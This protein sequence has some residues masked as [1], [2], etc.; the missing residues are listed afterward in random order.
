MEPQLPDG[1]TVGVNTADKKIVDGKIY[2]IKHGD[3]IR[4]KVLYTL[5]NGGLRLKSFN[6][7]EHPDEIYTFAQR[8]EQQI[9]VIGRVFW[10]SVLY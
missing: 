3:M 2:A 1:S 6:H 10:S 5:P 4:I 7:D 8:E 9:E